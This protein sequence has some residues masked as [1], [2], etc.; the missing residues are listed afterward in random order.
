MKNKVLIVVSIMFLTQL[1]FS[2]WRCNCPTPETFE[3]NYTDVSIIPYDTSGFNYEVVNDTVN[4]NTFGLG[5][6]VNFE[7]IKVAF[8]FKKLAT[9]GF[10]SALAFSDCDCVEDEFI[11]P[12]PIN[13]FNIYMLDTQTEQRTD[14]TQNFRIYSYSNEL[15][16]LN[17]FFEQRENWHDGFQIEL[18]EYDS[19]PNS[20]VFEVEVFLDSGKTFSNHT[21]IINFYE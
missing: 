5:I 6:L 16:P 1:F 11:Y 4:K 18:V 14:I 9:L 2:C 3:N 12:D 21:G 15:I 8:N 7:T 17:E 19:M 20:G 10:N 13:N